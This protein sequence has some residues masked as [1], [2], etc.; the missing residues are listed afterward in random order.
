MRTLQK[1][2]LILSFL[3][4]VGKIP[5]VNHSLRRISGKLVTNQE[6]KETEQ[7]HGGKKTC[8]DLFLF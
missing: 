1:Y 5:D 7:K 8:R 2:F 6:L 3:V 4:I